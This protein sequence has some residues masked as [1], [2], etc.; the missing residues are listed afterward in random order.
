MKDCQDI[1]ELVERSK[2]E[3]IPVKDRLAIR[4]H[5]SI[6][7]NCRTYFKDS[8]LMDELLT[9]KFRHLSEYA[10]SLEEKE[11]LKQLLRSKESNS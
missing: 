9:R 2:L 11:R 6:C 5:N 8:A 1:T 3:R 10:F 4:F 7:K